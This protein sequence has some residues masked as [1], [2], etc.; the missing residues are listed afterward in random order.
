MSRHLKVTESIDRDFLLGN[1]WDLLEFD[2]CIDDLK[3]TNWYREVTEKYIHLRFD[4][5]QEALLK[6]Q[7]ATGTDKTYGL[8]NALQGKIYSWTLDWPVEKEL[9]IPPMFAAD[10]NIFPELDQNTEFKIQ[11]KYKFGYFK[12]ICDVLGEDTFRFSRITVHDTDAKIF[13]HVDYG[14]GLRLHIPIISNTASRFLFGDL[15]DRSYGFDVGRVYL[16]NAKIPHC[17][18]NQG[19]PRVHIISDPGIDKLMD[20][21]NMKVS[22]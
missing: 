6:T 3:I 4:F 18:I 7:Y 12:K 13:K 11:N 2:I 9:P 17:T 10:P 21:L 14:L 15:L 1:E 16:I 20:L 22:I 19:D 5:S 8:E